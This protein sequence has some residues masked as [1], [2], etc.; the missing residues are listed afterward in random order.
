MSALL[1]PGEISF[2]DSNGNP[3]TAGKIFFYIPN[4]STPKNTWQDQGQTILNTN[5]VILDAAGR[6]IIWGTGTYRQVVQDSIGNLIWDQIVTTPASG[7]DLSGTGTPP[8]TDYIG[9]DGTTLTQ[10]FLS[11]NNRIV[12]TIAALR[13]LL[14]TTYTRAWIT[15]YYAAGDG[16]GGE[17]WYDP[18]DTTSTDNGGTIIVASDGGRWKLQNNGT[19]S[20]AQ[21]GGI[22]NGSLTTTQMYSAISSAWTAALAQ[23]FDIYFP[24]GTYDCGINNFPFRNT[25]AGLLDCKGIKIVCAGNDTILKTTSVVGADV[26]QL[27]ALQNFS[28]VGFPTLSSTVTG[29]A[30]GSNGCSVTN[31]WDNIYLELNAYKCA[32]LDK[33]TFIDG[34]RAF[35]IQT[36]TGSNL[37]GRLKAIVWADS[38]TEGFGYEPD[39]ATAFNHP[40]DIDVD[41]QARNCYI[42][43][44]GV[45]APS[46]VALSSSMTM[47]V[48][49][50]AKTLD[51]QHDV[52]LQRMHGYWVEYMTGGNKTAAQRRI[53][54]NTG[55]P[56]FATDTIVDSFQAAYL[57]DGFIRGNGN[58]GQCDYKAQIG[59]ATAGSS[60]LVGNTQYCDILLD[61]GGTA[62]IADLNS[63]NSGGN[64][65]ANTK[66][67]VSPVTASAG[68]WPTDWSQNSNQNKLSFGSR[69]TGSFTG[70][71]TG[72]TTVPTGTIKYSINADVVTLE[73]PLI[74]GTSNSTTATITGLVTDVI[75]LSIQGLIAITIDNGVNAFSRV[76]IDSTGTI[77]L[78]YG[79]TNGIFTASGTKGITF[80]TLTYRRA[81]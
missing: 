28:V 16:G 46:T 58:K 77:T 18:T 11:K 17:Y 47:G 80:C 61:I 7:A 32:G 4:T 49:V 43:V 13:G 21:F 27:N 8:G 64:T 5:P 24:P 69:Y 70:S 25:G 30:S 3:L 67:D 1:Q 15:G 6:A 41:I 65:M 33:G 34:G 74:S 37:R 40:T 72:C 62:A 12:D 31:G 71:L 52:L 66:L 14:H 68:I 19:V 81:G 44:K 50:K 42:G 75:P 48:R 29:S 60:G 10:F 73:I 51:C 2:F 56:W 63:I 23:V 78:F 35:T 55:S 20:V 9:F 38:C 79:A 53:N 57:K 59:G 76:N 39:L 22:G 26:L 45:A 36:G 54:P